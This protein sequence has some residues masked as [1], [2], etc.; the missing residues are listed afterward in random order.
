MTRKG[1]NT[2]VNEELSLHDPGCTSCEDN[3]DWIPRNPFFDMTEPRNIIAIEAKKTLLAKE[4]I[5][6][7]E[8]V[9]TI[10]DITSAAFSIADLMIEEGLKRGKQ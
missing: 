2:C 10:N 8:Y 3:S 7:L 9:K 1:C 4:S 5:E 6:D